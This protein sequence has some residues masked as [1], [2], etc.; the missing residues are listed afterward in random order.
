MSFQPAQNQVTFLPKTSN[1]TSSQSYFL[2]G[3]LAG[4]N[5]WSREDKE[6]MTLHQLKIW[7]IIARRLSIT[8]AAEELHIRQ[9]SVTQQIKLLE[10]EFRVKLYN[11]NHRGVEL[12]PVGRLSLKYAKKIL[13]HVDNLERDVRRS[14]RRTR[15]KK[16]SQAS[17]VFYRWKNRSTDT[18]RQNPFRA[19]T[20]RASSCN[21]CNLWLDIHIPL[22]L[23]CIL[24]VRQSLRSLHNLKER[25][26]KEINK[27]AISS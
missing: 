13:S 14:V 20:I 5:Q 16:H 7:T 9:P 23:R 1:F 25:H 8:K 24:A 19:L 17:V 12:T 11:V 22:L 15:K 18:S 6:T 10:K 21:L 26:C 4:S 27:K 3:I 2:I